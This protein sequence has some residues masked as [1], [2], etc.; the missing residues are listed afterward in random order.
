MI[1][2]IH[3]VRYGLCDWDGVT[4][5]NRRVRTRMHGGVAEVGG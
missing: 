2:D 4:D 5:S 3:G 1:N